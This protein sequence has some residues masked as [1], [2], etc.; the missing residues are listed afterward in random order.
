MRH[1]NTEFQIIFARMK[2]NAV[3]IDSRENLAHIIHGLV[4]IDLCWLGIDE[5]GCRDGVAPTP[6]F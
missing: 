4:D 2:E 3:T 6:C 5:R 1:F